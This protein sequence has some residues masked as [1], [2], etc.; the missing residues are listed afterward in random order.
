MAP[1]AASSYLL[2]R[3][4]GRQN[5][6]WLL[7]S[8]EWVDAEEALRMGWSGRSASPRTCWPTPADTL[9]SWPP[10]RSRA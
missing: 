1:E 9:K 3:L 5:A 2:P 4:V 10:A 8:S 6:A 7:M